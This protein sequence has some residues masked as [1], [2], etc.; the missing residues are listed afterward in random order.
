MG[1]A[2]RI[3]SASTGRVVSTLSSSATSSSGSR[4]TTGEGHSDV[5]TAAILSPENPFQ[6]ITASLDGCVKVWDF[7]DAVLLR[8]IDVGKPISKMCAHKRF[9][10]CVFIASITKSK[11]NH[12]GDGMC[13]GKFWPFL[14]NLHLAL[15]KGNTIVY[16]ISLG[17]SGSNPPKLDGSIRIG[18]TKAAASMGISSDGA[19]LVVIGGNKA[20]VASITS[21]DPAFSK[22]VSP[23]RLTC[24]A[25]HPTESYF[26]TGDEIG[27]VRLWYCLN[28]Q[29]S[30]TLGS[31]GEKKAQTV[32]M[33]WHAHAVS[34]IAFTPNGA[35]LLSGG[36][37]SV[38][39]IWQ[40]HSGKREY[41]PRLGAPISTIAVRSSAES[42]EEYLVG[43][44]DGSF[45]FVNSA[46][47]SVIRSAARVRLGE[48]YFLIFEVP[49][50]K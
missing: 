36:E 32:T 18:K 7:L 26:A 38:L 16:R 29:A 24:L 4:I 30:A 3:Y 50:L 6:L 22:F 8:T 15:E 10:D 33:H 13:C 46:S 39:V 48:C 47:L 27:Q 41:V 25:F 49:T 44:S 37:E 21:P 42:E 28:E 23:E 5:I 12:R 1:S 34:A 40:L 17:S 43:L 31:S 20:Y 2:V 35:Y 14:P 19:W 45:V 9:K 11:K